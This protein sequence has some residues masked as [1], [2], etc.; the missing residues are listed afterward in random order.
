MIVCSSSERVSDVSNAS[1]GDRFLD[2][3]AIKPAR[4]MI[5]AMNERALER[6]GWEGVWGCDLGIEMGG[7][8]GGYVRRRGVVV[9]IASWRWWRGAGACCAERP[10]VVP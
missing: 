4:A 2:E 7:L 6:V 9:A 8:D 5:A 3:I 1:F 10:G